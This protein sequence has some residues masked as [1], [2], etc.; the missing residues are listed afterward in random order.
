M[1]GDDL[2]PSIMMGAGLLS[3]KPAGGAPLTLTGCDANQKFSFF[4][5]NVLVQP[6]C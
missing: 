2:R 4:W 5:G 3:I 6:F 1:A